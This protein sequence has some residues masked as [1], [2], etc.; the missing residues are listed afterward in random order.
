M[1]APMSIPILCLPG[2]DDD[3]H[4]GDAEPVHIEEGAAG[5]L[6]VSKLVYQ[7]LSI[8]LI[9]WNVM[10][11]CNNVIFIHSE[12]FQNECISA[13]VGGLTFC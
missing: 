5:M 1:G 8:K 7:Y 4:R 9:W 10:Q 3:E 13:T 2:V 6:Q 12:N 11:W